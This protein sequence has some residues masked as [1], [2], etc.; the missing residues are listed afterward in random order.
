MTKKEAQE[1]LKTLRAAIEHY[2]HSYQVENVSLI[3]D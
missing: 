3:S 1:R 2:L